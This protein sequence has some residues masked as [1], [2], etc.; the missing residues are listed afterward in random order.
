M[1]KKIFNEHQIESVIHFA[2]LK[3]VKESEDFP[4]KYYMNNVLGSLILF[5]EMELAGVNK[6]VFSSSYSSRYLR[7]KIQLVYS[8]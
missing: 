3:A 7:I 8:I 1:L 6:I 2:R 4:I 5:E